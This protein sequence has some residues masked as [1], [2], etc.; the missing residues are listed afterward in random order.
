M[1]MGWVVKCVFRN[2]VI[3]RRF[4]SVLLRIGKILCKD[5]LGA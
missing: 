4:E 2:K 3:L 1:C 5:G